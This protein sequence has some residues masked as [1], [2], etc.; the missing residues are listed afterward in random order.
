M[1]LRT[2]LLFAFLGLVASPA[3]ACNLTE[4]Q[5]GIAW[6]KDQCNV[7]HSQRQCDGSGYM[8]THARNGDANG[9][10]DGFANCHFGTDDNEMKQKSNVE[11]CFLND[12][13]GLLRVACAVYGGCPCEVTNTCPP[14][15]TP[16]P[17]N[18]ID[19]NQP[20]KPAIDN[21]TIVIADFT[22][23]GKGAYRSITLNFTRDGVNIFSLSTYAVNFDNEGD[24]VH[25]KITTYDKSVDDVSRHK[26]SVAGTLELAP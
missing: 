22:L 17:V 6:C 23:T 12:P 9:V 8:A 7:T 5:V 26:Y 19:F 18:K 21:K 2:A 15:P 24:K 3:D 13:K 25:I 11:A 10:R 20:M 1:F 14:T 4:A 16:P